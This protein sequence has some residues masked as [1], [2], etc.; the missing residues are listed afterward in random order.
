MKIFFNSRISNGRTC[1]WIWTHRLRFEM[2]KQGPKKQTQSSPNQHLLQKTLVM[3]ILPKRIHRRYL[4]ISS[5]SMPENARSVPEKVW[6]RISSWNRRIPFEKRLHHGKH[7]KMRLSRGRMYV[8][9]RKWAH[10]QAFGRIAKVPFGPHVYFGT[11]TTRI[12]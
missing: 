12:D 8:Q 3:L 1:M 2:R 5:H 10:G 7:G 6:R 4:A 9:S 11:Q